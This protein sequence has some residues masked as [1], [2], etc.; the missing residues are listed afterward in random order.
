MTEKIYIFNVLVSIDY[1]LYFHISYLKKSGGARATSQPLPPLRACHR[2]VK[3]LQIL[4]EFFYS[5]IKLLNYFPHGLLMN[6]RTW[7]FVTFSF[8]V[9]VSAFDIS[10]LLK[11]I[12]FAFIF[13]SSNFNLSSCKAFC[14][15]HFNLFKLRHFNYVIISFKDCYLF[16]FLLQVREVMYRACN[17]LNSD[18]IFKALFRDFQ[19]VFCLQID[20]L[21]SHTINSKVSTSHLAS[22]RAVLKFLVHCVD[23]EFPE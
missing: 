10:L 18:C 15:F 13:K 8:T 4:V 20:A 19:L 12:L 16:K 11:F 3:A 22:L 2:L 7:L 23:R 21:G 1:L 14:D 17:A 5:F 9:Q 6:F